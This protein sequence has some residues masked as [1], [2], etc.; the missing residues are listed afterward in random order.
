MATEETDMAKGAEEAAAAKAAEAQVEQEPAPTRETKAQEEQPQPTS[1]EAPDRQ[2]HEQPKEAEPTEGER[3]SISPSPLPEEEQL[4]H[5][6]G[7]QNNSGVQE[8]SAAQQKAGQ[9]EQQA[10]HQGSTPDLQSKEQAEEECQEQRQHQDQ[11]QEQSGQGKEQQERQESQPQTESAPQPQPEPHQQEEQ[12]Q[13]QEQPKSQQHEQQEKTQPQA[14]SEAQPQPQPQAEAQPQPQ[15]QPQPHAE[16]PPQPQAQPQPHAEAQPQPQPQPQPQAQSQAKPQPEAQQQTTP[17]PVAELNLPTCHYEA[18]GISFS[19]KDTEIKKAYQFKSRQT[20]PDKNPDDPHATRRFQRVSEAYKVLSNPAQRSAYDAESFV[21]KAFAKL[22]GLI[23]DQRVVG[24]VQRCFA[25]PGIEVREISIE[26]NVLDRLHTHLPYLKS[27]SGADLYP[28]SHNMSATAV[29]LLAGMPASVERGKVLLG[30]LAKQ[31]TGQ[32]APQMGVVVIVPAKFLHTVPMMAMQFQNLTWQTGSMIRHAG[33]DRIVIEGGMAIPQVVARIQQWIEWRGQLLLPKGEILDAWQYGHECEDKGSHIGLLPNT[34]PDTTQVRNLFC[35]VLK[36]NPSTQQKTALTSLAARTLQMTDVRK[37]TTAIVRAA[38]SVAVHAEHSALSAKVGAPLL[39]AL[40]AAQQGSRVGASVHQRFSTSP[41]FK[42]MA[43]LGTALNEPRDGLLLRSRGFVAAKEATPDDGQWHSWEDLLR[44]DGS[45]AVF[46]KDVRAW[47]KER[48][49]TLGF[50]P[51]PAEWYTV[52]AV[53]ASVMKVCINQS[54]ELDMEKG[55]LRKPTQASGPSAPATS[56]TQSS[57]FAGGAGAAQGHPPDAS[58]ASAS[59]GAQQAT[60]ILEN[61]T[62]VESVEDVLLEL[63]RSSAD[64]AA[65]L[66]L[67]AV[68]QHAQRRVSDSSSRLSKKWY[69]Q[70]K[71]SFELKK[72]GNNDFRIKLCSAGQ[73]RASARAGERTAEAARRRELTVFKEVLP[74][75]SAEQLPRSLKGPELCG[76]LVLLGEAR[77]S[78]HDIGLASAIL[79]RLCQRKGKELLSEGAPFNPAQ[80][81]RSVVNCEKLHKQ[82]WDEECLR[83]LLEAAAMDMHDMKPRLRASLKVVRDSLRAATCKPFE[84]QCKLNGRAGSLLVQSAALRLQV[85]LNSKLEGSSDRVIFSPDYS[86]FRSFAELC[87]ALA[88]LAS[89]MFASPGMQKD[90]KDEILKAFEKLADACKELDKLPPSAVPADC[91]GL[92]SM[93][94]AFS[95]LAKEKS[96]LPKIKIALESL[97]KVM[98]QCN[99]DEASGWNPRVVAAVAH[100]YSISKVPN[101][102]LFR[103]IGAT[104]DRAASGQARA[105]AKDEAPKL[106][107]S[108]KEAG[109][110]HL[111]EKFLKTLKD[112]SWFKRSFRDISETNLP[113]VFAG[114]VHVRDTDAAEELGRMLQKDRGMKDL[115]FTS[116]TAMLKECSALDEVSGSGSSSSGLKASLLKAATASLGRSKAPPGEDVESLLQVAQGDSKALQ[117][118]REAFTSRR[119]LELVSKSDLSWKDLAANFGSLLAPFAS[120]SVQVPRLEAA[121]GARFLQVLDNISGSP[122]ADNAFLRG[123]VPAALEFSEAAM[124]SMPALVE[125]IAAGLCRTRMP[126]PGADEAAEVHGLIERLLR[127]VSDADLADDGCDD[128]LVTW[129]GHLDDRATDSWAR[130]VGSSSNERRLDSLETQLGAREN[131]KVTGDIKDALGAN[132]LPTLL[133]KSRKVTWLGGRSVRL[134]PPRPRAAVQQLA[135]V[136]GQLLGPMLKAEVLTLDPEEEPVLPEPATE[137]TGHRGAGRPGLPPTSAPRPSSALQGAS[138]RATRTEGDRSRSR[139]SRVSA[140]GSVVGDL[141]PDGRPKPKAAAAKAEAAQK[142]IVLQVQGGWDRGMA[143]TVAGRYVIHSTNHG[144]NVY[145]RAVPDDTMVLLYYWDDRDGEESS[146]WWFGPEVGGEEVWAHNADPGAKGLPPPENWKVLHSDTVDPAM[147]VIPTA[148]PPPPGGPPPKGGGGGSGPSV[149]GAAP[150]QARPSFRG[151]APGGPPRPAPAAQGPGPS[152][153]PGRHGQGPSASPGRH[154]QDSF[155]G[156]GRS[157]ADSGRATGSAPSSAEDSSPQ[158]SGSGERDNELKSWL[159]SLDQGAGTMLQYYDVLAAEFDSDLQQIAAAKIDGDPSVGIMGTVDPTFWEV[160][161]VTKVG[162]RMLF[163]HGIAKL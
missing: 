122:D 123:L 31:V 21:K 1:A 96:F 42:T 79:K 78:H 16:A 40:V 52:P 126:R 28:I 63:T 58:G 104:I 62:L 32:A 68:T 12:H 71:M 14:Q 153:S 22:G 150:S 8:P 9:Q 56:T 88:S 124:A 18:L 89:T 72:V 105:I 102:K 141:P 34:D 145:R 143:D 142:R 54:V 98:L 107:Q 128:Q 26:K 59:A 108:F 29:I 69:E 82:S 119:R 24:W 84:D 37:L 60:A 129:V 146:G 90:N 136:A 5:Q 44:P 100:A 19:A 81:M 11:P 151:P 154:G 65:Y 48:T 95:Q 115:S 75:L 25:M 35:H 139:D 46:W 38:T 53:M 152:A 85:E 64:P 76:L 135:E 125:A 127:A 74:K 49:K 7:Q 17:P 91:E 67:G 101:E 155:W 114:M 148:R 83:T 2:Q 111:L 92:Q 156:G 116:L 97:S 147:K 10:E 93:A 103:K 112:E 109:F 23:P 133:V 162:H 51:P 57:G 41:Q 45:L 110:L 87:L 33:G 113:W 70:H 131:R 130:P 30:E 43:S 106:I 61:L 121:C 149:G 134:T 50:Q 6:E 73:A 140:R 39:C 159:R 77:T 99:M 144:K 137:G 132:W 86:S 55:M 13:Q 120:Q 138:G 20:H 94:S 36:L 15:A 118:L 27:Q 161:K 163:A 47:V 4:L 158:A 3:V 160:V 66:E 117:T 80:L 157:S